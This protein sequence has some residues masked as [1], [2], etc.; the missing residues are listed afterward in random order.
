[1]SLNRTIKTRYPVFESQFVNAIVFTMELT[2][3]NANN[4]FGIFFYLFLII[5]VLFFLNK[6]TENLRTWNNLVNN[7]IYL[8]QIIH[9]PSFIQQLISIVI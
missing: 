6:I 2:E 8:I 3:Q 4:I 5:K 7:L 9:M 1:M